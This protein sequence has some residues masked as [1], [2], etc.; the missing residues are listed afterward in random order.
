MQSQTSSLSV[1]RLGWLVLIWSASV[2]AL[3]GVAF[4]FH[5][6]MSLAGLVA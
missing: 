6:M 2:V 3:A 4:A 5:M 1:Q